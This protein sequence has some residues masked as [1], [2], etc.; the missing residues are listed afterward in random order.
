MSSLTQN[1][2]H[3][4]VLSYNIVCLWA[5]NILS[6]SKIYPPNMIPFLQFVY[7]IPKFYLPAHIQKCQANFSFNFTPLVGCTDGEAPNMVGQL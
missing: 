5:R 4:I 7:L 2:P 1:V 6:R 3:Q